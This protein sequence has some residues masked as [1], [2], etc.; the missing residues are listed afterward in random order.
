MN[1]DKITDVEVE[2]IHTWDAPDFVDAYISYANYNGEPMTDN[3][4]DTINNDR[5]F[6]LAQ[7]HSRLY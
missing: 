2:G 6:V 1:R 7:V 3:Q 5:E 4:L